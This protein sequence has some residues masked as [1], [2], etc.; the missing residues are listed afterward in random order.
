MPL[1]FEIERIFKMR[2]EFK[3]Q[4]ARKQQQENPP[5]QKVQEEKTKIS[6]LIKKFRD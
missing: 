1:S 6:E 5:C 4:A 2:Q 3:E